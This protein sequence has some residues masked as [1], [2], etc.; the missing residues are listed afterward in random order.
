MASIW[1][2]SMRL[3]VEDQ[4]PQ[5]LLFTPFLLTTESAAE[6]RSFQTALA[7]EMKPRGMIEQMYVADIANLSWDVLRLR[8][9]KAAIINAACQRAL[10]T[11]LHQILPASG[12]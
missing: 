1:E 5:R 10:Q 3:E 12:P 8:R 7:L 4:D 11:L 9:C 6:F 2:E